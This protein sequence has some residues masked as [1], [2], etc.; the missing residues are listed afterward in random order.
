MEPRPKGLSRR[1]FLQETGLATLGIFL[2]AC[3]PVTPSANEGTAAR[4]IAAP[5][6]PN[7][8]SSVV[9][10][11]WSLNKIEDPV[12]Q[13]IVGPLLD[14][15]PFSWY[16]ADLGHNI[17]ITWNPNYPSRQ[18]GKEPT[19]G[20]TVFKEND[21]GE[22][23]ALINMGP[24][25]N[26]QSYLKLESTYL[27]KYW[28]QQ[29]S[30]D[31]QTLLKDIIKISIGEELI[32]ACSLFNT[33]ELS[34]EDFASFFGIEPISG[35]EKAQIH[36]FVV[37]LYYKNNSLRN[38]VALEEIVTKFVRS[39][40][41]EN[42]NQRKVDGMLGYDPSYVH[43]AF[44]MYLD[45]DNFLKELLKAKKASSLE[46][47][48]QVLVTRILIKIQGEP[49][50]KDRPKEE[51]AAVADDLAKAFITTSFTTDPESTFEKILLSHDFQVNHEGN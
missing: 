14:R 23:A 37:N 17:S 27:A 16:C 20:V 2:A 50:Y 12:L 51:I 46:Q 35:L 28:Q 13:E 33:T 3:A 10:K 1:E 48:Q 9:E 18:E 4:P 25:E 45:G 39:Q 40:L 49:L 6:T 29:S 30:Q 26:F 31:Q 43:V 5:G 44:L 24:P 38:S 41:V 22:K 36:G 8:R 47:L 7:E 32:H 19:L 42:D 11:I 15:E 21:E 34:P